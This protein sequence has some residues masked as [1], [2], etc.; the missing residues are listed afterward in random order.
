VDKHI[1]SRPSL[2]LARPDPPRKEQGGAVVARV[3][4]SA[5]TAAEA[6]GGSAGTFACSACPGMAR[7]QL[8][9]N[10]KSGLIPNLQRED[11]PTADASATLLYLKGL[12]SSRRF[13]G[14]FFITRVPK[15][16][17]CG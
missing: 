8:R 2:P 1:H 14:P 13:N 5:G 3:E 7:E 10:R 9:I 15:N 6:A 11:A 4:P 12:K 16:G 17:L